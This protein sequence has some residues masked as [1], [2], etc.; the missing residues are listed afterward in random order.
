MYTPE[1]RYIRKIDKRASFLKDGSE[2]LGKLAE[3]V[4]IDFF[5]MHFP[6][7]ITVRPATED[8]D[9]GVQQ[10]VQGKQIDATTF[11]TPKE[12]DLRKR[13]GTNLKS[14]IQ[15]NLFMFQLDN[16]C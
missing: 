8:E 9:S 14:S 2:D 3:S 7:Q 11:D 1:N 16:K 6:G 15:K 12:K 10:I 4:V 13:L 5:N